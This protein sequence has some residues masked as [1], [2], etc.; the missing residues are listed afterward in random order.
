[1]CIFVIALFGAR[2]AKQQEDFFYYFWH[3]YYPVV[4]LI[5]KLQGETKG[6]IGFL[7]AIFVNVPIGMLIYG[8]F[9]GLVICYFRSRRH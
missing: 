1:M 4:A 7:A 8:L 6:E 3:I 9:I 5:G 2:T